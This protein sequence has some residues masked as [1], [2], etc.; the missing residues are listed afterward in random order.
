MFLASGDLG[1]GPLTPQSRYPVCKL[2]TP[3]PEN[4]IF[5]PLLFNFL[6]TLSEMRISQPSCYQ[7]VPHSLQKTPGVG[8]PQEICLIFSSVYALLP[9][10]PGA[11]CCGA[12]VSCGLFH[13]SCRSRR[14]PVGAPLFSHGRRLLSP[15]LFTSLPD[16]FPHNERGSTYPLTQMG[17]SARSSLCACPLHW[18]ASV[19]ALQQ[20]GLCGY[21]IFA[22]KKSSAFR[23]NSV[24]CLAVPCTGGLSWIAQF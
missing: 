3:T 7:A 9:C 16:S 2:V 19:P 10:L 4:A 13:R 18:R 11:D 24:H 15:F 14:R 1:I 5:Y 8:I 6:R 17:C 20:A 21:S 23:S 22:R 12:F